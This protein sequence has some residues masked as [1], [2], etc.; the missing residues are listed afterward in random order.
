MAFQYITRKRY[1]LKNLPI[2][3]DWR[4]F[5]P[6]V[7]EDKITEFSFTDWKAHAQFRHPL[8]G[9]IIVEFNTQDSSPTIEF[10][11]G[12]MYLIKA[13]SI[14]VDIIPGDYI[15]DCKFTDEG[16]VERRLIFESPVGIIRRQTV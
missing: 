7:Q 9:T 6:I 11:D 13:K 12:G 8:D 16:G 3:D 15:W 5:I 4:E 1:E 2:G 14:T 10:A